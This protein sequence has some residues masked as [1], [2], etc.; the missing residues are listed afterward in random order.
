MT[1]E[2]MKRLWPVAK[3]LHESRRDFVWGKTGSVRETW[4]EYSNSY[5]HNPIAYV[6]LALRQAE[7]LYEAGLI[8]Q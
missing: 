3:I 1:L 2:Q 5:S 8:N 4:P 6:D 7:A